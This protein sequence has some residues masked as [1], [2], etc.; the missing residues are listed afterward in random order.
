MKTPHKY[1]NGRCFS[2]QV[3]FPVCYLSVEIAK[4]RL[5]SEINVY[6]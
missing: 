6:V 4:V 2:G 5:Y 1:T 3:L